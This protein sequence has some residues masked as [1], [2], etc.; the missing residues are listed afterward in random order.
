[1]SRWGKSRFDESLVK[2]MGRWKREPAKWPAPCSSEVSASA[3]VAGTASIYQKASGPAA[4][5]TAQPTTKYRSVATDG[6]ASKREAKRAAVLRLMQD[7]GAIR[8]LREQVTYLLI[9]RQLAPDGIVAERAVTYTVDFDYEEWAA[10]AWRHVAEDSKG[11]RTQQYII[12]R[13]LLRF[14]HGII[15]RET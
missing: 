14:V 5:G 4:L 6:Y 11:F 8:N 2:K 7:A 3:P 15:L 12:R 1:M 9:P 13:K 10:D